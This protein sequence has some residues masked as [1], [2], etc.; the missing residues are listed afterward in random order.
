MLSRCSRFLLVA[1][2]VLLGGCA[3]TSLTSLKSPSAPR[4]GPGQILVVAAYGDL[5]WRRDVESEFQRR[6]P[7]FV[8]SVNV[9]EIGDLANPQAITAHLQKDPLLEALLVLAPA[10][11]GLSQSFVANQYYATTVAKPWANTT[12]SLYDRQDERVVWRAD[13]STAGNAYASWSDIR[14]SFV[15]KVVTRLETD[16]VVSSSVRLARKSRILTPATLTAGWRTAPPDLVEIIS[17]TE[18]DTRPILIGSVFDRTAPAVVLIEGNRGTGTAFLISKDGL[19][20]TNYHVVTGQSGLRAKFHDGTVASTRVLRSDESSDLALIEIQCPG[21]C[22][23]IEIAPAVRVE[24]GLEIYALGH[25]AGLTS[26]LTSGIVSAL[27]QSRGVT[28]VQ[29]DAALNKGNSGGPI[30]E[31]QS[32]TVIGIVS[33]KLS[34]AEGLG[35]G[36]SA[37]DALRIMGVRFR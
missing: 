1:A 10:G 16:G 30:V 29:V 27:R 15:G 5:T 36:V 12:A 19:A 17:L 35:F 23:T 8:A 33:F 2:T 37:E 14:H 24:P 3:S 34:E 26:T 11:A 32:G 28:L 25:P 6:H 7:A 9:I 21:E 18:D 22:A 31:R 20:L 13:A 4:Y